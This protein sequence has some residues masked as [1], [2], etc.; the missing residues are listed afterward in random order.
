MRRCRRSAFHASARQIEVV[1]DGPMML[2][3][4]IRHLGLDRG[5]VVRLGGGRLGFYEEHADD[6]G[7]EGAEEDDEEKA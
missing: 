6:E 4:A 7:G 5:S 3:S 2:A 1:P